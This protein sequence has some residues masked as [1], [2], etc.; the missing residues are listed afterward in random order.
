M[1]RFNHF[2]SVVASALSHQGRSVTMKAIASIVWTGVILFG[3][4][5]HLNA[6][7]VVTTDNQYDPTPNQ[8]T[9]TPT[10][11]PIN[12]SRDVLLGLMPSASA[13]NFQL[14]SSAGIPILT[15]GQFGTIQSGGSHPNWATV[16]NGSGAGTS[17]TY[18]FNPT[19]L[20][21]IVVYGGWNDN[22][23]DQ[24]EYT[25]SYS[26][27]NGASF[28]QLTATNPSVNFNPSVPG[29]SQSAVRTT[30]SDPTGLL[31]GGA[32]IDELQFNFNYGVENGYV[33]ISE[34]VANTVPEPSSIVALVGLCGMGLV[35]VVRRRRRCPSIALL[36]RVLG[37][38]AVCLLVSAPTLFAAPVFTNTSGTSVY[39]IPTVNDLL[40]DP[41]VTHIDRD[42]S[43]NVVTDTSAPFGYA[44]GG[45]TPGSVAKLT[46]GSFGQNGTPNDGSFAGI[47][48]AGSLNNTGA[49]NDTITYALDLAAHP[50][51]FNVSSIGIYTGWHDTGRSEIKAAVFYS[52]VASPNTFTFLGNVDYN[53]NVDNFSSLADSSGGWLATNVADIEFAF[54]GQENGGV[55]YRE[56]TVI[57][58]PV[59]EPSTIVALIGLCGMGLVGLIRYRRRKAA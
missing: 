45:Q 9:F 21:N 20:Q 38:A 42:G 2:A 27:N 49:G 36:A 1:L 37:L 25:I 17:L 47:V 39:T 48:G 15:N 16:G 51:G 14:E 33:G 40:L 55:G 35:F 32:L 54:P 44:D 24:Q 23:R 28:T 58:S 52:T 3:L 26:T 30:F 56:L 11:D 22:G 6:A 34:I 29:S 8:A 18:S 31:A 43:G 4:G 41:S 13:G 7:T 19:V 46:D 57:G 5:S 12:T 53:G 59:P 10:Y 50:Q